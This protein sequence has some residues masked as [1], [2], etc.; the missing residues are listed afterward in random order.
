MKQEIIGEILKINR[1]KVFNESNKPLSQLE[2]SL[3]IGWE[4]PSTLSRIENGEVIPSVYTVRKI[5][6]ALNV[7]PF[8]I[9]SILI[10]A[11]YLDF[12]DI[13]QEY[14]KEMIDDTKYKFE[15]SKYPVN[16]L[17]YD[18][19]PYIYSSYY[20]N[21]IGRKIFY[22]KGIYAKI[23]EWFSN[24][25]DLITLLFDKKYRMN[26]ILLNWEEFTSIVVSNMYILYDGTD[27]ENAQIKRFSR[28]PQFQKLWNLAKN[29]TINDFKD[30]NIPFIYQSNVIGKIA[31]K[32]QEIPIIN[33][34]RFFIEQFLPMNLEDS[35]KLESIYIKI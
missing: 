11:K 29:K 30:N 19:P 26:K 33:D 35:E 27:E 2:L 10:K 14:I 25:N 4:N 24:N 17:I 9:H 32:V 6:T 23:Q 21:K 13:T 34:H 12:S 1:L 20:M 18:N 15:Y 7:D 8:K 3:K 16:L 22:G 5:L 28:F 31:F